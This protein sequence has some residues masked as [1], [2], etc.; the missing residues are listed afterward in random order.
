M[1]DRFSDENFIEAARTYQNIKAP[2]ELRQ[3][4][5]ME[6]AEYARPQESAPKKAAFRPVKIYKLASLA[7]CIAIMAAALPAWVTDGPEVSDIPD[8]SDSPQMMRMAPEPAV[9]NELVLEEEA[10]PEEEPA[11]ANKPVEADVTVPDV[12]EPVPEDLGEAEE[13]EDFGQE[14]GAEAVPAISV[15]KLLPGMAAANTNLNNLEVRIVEAE[16]GSCTV[17]VTTADHKTAE[18]TLSQD[19]EDGHWEVQGADD[20]V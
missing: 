6:A 13:P 11:A 17:E 16:D 9:A 20:E 15:G 10:D 8:V 4:I 3:R 12:K 14:D 19:G 18:V 5:L 1:S 7:A 2:S